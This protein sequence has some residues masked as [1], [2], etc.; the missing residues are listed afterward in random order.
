MVAE[1][2]EGA[3]LVE[4]DAINGM[5]FHTARRGHRL[6]TGSGEAEPVRGAVRRELEV[7]A[8]L[9]EVVLLVLVRIEQGRGAVSVDVDE[10][11]VA[12]MRRRDGEDRMV[13][14]RVRRAVRDQGKIEAFP[15]HRRWRRLRDRRGRDLERD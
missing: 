14:G 3:R 15:R 11:Q 7:L 9:E 10:L 13:G 2:G 5:V 8:T 12:V 4:L 6:R 1:V